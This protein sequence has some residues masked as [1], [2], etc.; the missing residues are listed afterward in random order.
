MPI[1]FLVHFLYI[2]KAS[3]KT[4]KQLQ[5][6]S[7]PPPLDVPATLTDVIDLYRALLTALGSTEWK[8][9]DSPLLVHCRYAHYFPFIVQ[10]NWGYKMNYSGPGN[11]P[12]IVK[13][14]YIMDK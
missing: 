6:A 2:L 13:P 3:P 12:I 11:Y 5:L 9:G 7:C 8:E 4:V 14:Y 10:L 1:T